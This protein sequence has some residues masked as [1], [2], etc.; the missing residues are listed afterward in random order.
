MRLLRK[1][2]PSIEY[3]VGSIILFYF[4]YFLFGGST[5]FIFAFI[6]TPDHQGSHPIGFILLTGLAFLLTLLIA[7]LCFSNI[8]KILIKYVFFYLIWY[9]ISCFLC[10]ILWLCHDAYSGNYFSKGGG[11]V[12]NFIIEN[13]W[14]GAAYGWLIV[15]LSI[16]Y[17]IS[18]FILS[19]FILRHNKVLK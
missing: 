18:I 12:I 13:L 15:L 8:K 19:F 7:R 4:F 16:P 10:T 6:S 14:L 1:L 3:L 9:C 5:R 2:L 11:Y 17:N